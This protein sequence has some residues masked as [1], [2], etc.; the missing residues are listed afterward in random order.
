MF[1]KKVILTLLLSL[2]VLVIITFV[3]NNK[4]DDENYKALFVHKV[5][6]KQKY[7]III[8]GDSR[9][10]RGIS[11][12][13]LGDK[14][15]LSALNLGF[16]SGGHSK[17]LFD[18]IDKHLNNNSP[19][20]T[21]ILGITPAS[22]TD[23]AAENGHIKRVLNRK[24]EEVL[25]YEY[26]FPIKLFFAPTTPYQIK[27]KLRH[28]P[29]NDYRQE[30]HINDG[31]IASWYDSPIP[32][33]A[34]KSYKDKFTKMKTEEEVIQSLYKKISEW[35]SEGIEVYGF[36][37]PSSKNMNELE[38]VVAEFNSNAFLKGFLNAGGSW[39]NIE[40]QYSSFDGS[41]LGKESATRL[42]KEIANKLS[43]G[44]IIKAYKPN[45]RINDIYKIS[46][47]KYK[48]RIKLTSDSSSLK[49]FNTDNSKPFNKIIF[50]EALS[51]AK[52]KN[53][54]K[55]S[56]EAVITYPEDETQ[57]V[58]GCKVNN[59][60]TEINTNYSTISGKPCKL[61]LDC[62]LPENYKNIDTL[63]I[64]INNKENSKFYLDSLKIW[65]LSN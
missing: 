45:L 25:E 22:L 57:A 14:L 43:T 9:I 30:F 46:N 13:I 10:Y 31:W 63:K 5:F 40:N 60:K 24:K 39:V 19:N 50:R 65:Y 44:Q 56:L 41:H 20:K 27:K 47:F 18:L 36:F 12:K 35:R 7:D 4:M 37:V 23:R 61:F 8:A 15:H 16:S 32:Y 33:R 38:K 49:L 11:A 2:V 48:R 21:I 54:S 55:I 52:S 26:L 28:K 29:S 53:I 59:K 34:L 64:Y 42:S 17:L 6:T 58:F 62:K 3:T 51:E 1:N